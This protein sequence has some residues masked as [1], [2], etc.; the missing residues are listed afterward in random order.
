MPPCSSEQLERRLQVREIM[1]IKIRSLF[2]ADV[3]HFLYSIYSFL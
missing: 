1:T 2:M 3:E